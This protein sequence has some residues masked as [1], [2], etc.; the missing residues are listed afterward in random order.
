MACLE[1]INGALAQM[2]RDPSVRFCEFDNEG[3]CLIA[4]ETQASIAALWQNVIAS[5]HEATAGSP[6][7]LFAPAA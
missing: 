3:H 7:G 5:Q 6:T 1:M 2:R 4:P